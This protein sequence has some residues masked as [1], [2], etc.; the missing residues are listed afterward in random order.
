M[1]SG[2]WPQVIPL[3]LH[4]VRH[5]GLHVSFLTTI[6]RLA[7][8]W[9]TS[10]YFFPHGVGGRPCAPLQCCV[11]SHPLLSL[12]LCCLGLFGLV[13]HLSPVLLFRQEA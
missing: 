8:S 11:A 1:I 6:G 2:I 10:I 7:T 9:S 3:V 12:C 4:M 5:S 13:A